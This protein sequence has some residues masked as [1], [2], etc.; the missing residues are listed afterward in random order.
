MHPLVVLMLVVVGEVW[1]SSLD[2]YEMILLV[3]SIQLVSAAVAAAVIAVVVVV[4]V[5]AAAAVVE[6]LSVQH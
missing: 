3:W 6:G 2:V 5:V 1:L 4:V